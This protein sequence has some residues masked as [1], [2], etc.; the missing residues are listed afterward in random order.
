[1][2]FGYAKLKVVVGWRW[3]YVSPLRRDTANGGTPGDCDADKT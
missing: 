3:K 2:A 1:M